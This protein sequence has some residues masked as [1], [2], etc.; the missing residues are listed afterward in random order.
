MYLHVKMIIS[1]SEFIVVKVIHWILT[2]SLTM[3]CQNNDASE[4]I[5]MA[6]SVLLATSSSWK[7]TIRSV[8]SSPAPI[9]RN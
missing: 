5:K 6:K 7:A 3:K 1:T 2:H 4:M 9:M 8:M